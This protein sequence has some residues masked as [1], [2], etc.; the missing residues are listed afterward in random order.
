[1]SVTLI[2]LVIRTSICLVYDHGK[3]A[4][5]L[6]IREN[7]DPRATFTYLAC[8]LAVLEIVRIGGIAIKESNAV[9][10]SPKNSN[11]RIAKNSRLIFRN[12]DSKSINFDA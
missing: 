3:G 12:L 2:Y 9:G 6:C 1:M 7:N 5:N 11:Q 4:L 10:L 8:N